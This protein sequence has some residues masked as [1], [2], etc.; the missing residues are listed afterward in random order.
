[1]HIAHASQ[2]DDSHHGSTRLHLNISD[3]V[4]IM[5]WAESRENGFSGCALWH[6]FPRRN[7]PIIRKFLAR[8]QKS[9]DTVDPI[10]SEQCYLAPIML[11]ALREQY[12][13]DPVIIYQRPGDAVFIPARCPYQ[14]R[15]PLPIYLPLT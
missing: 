4:N 8:V 1:M 9:A 15:I 14:V 7:T 5:T 6:I 12:C 3:T 2:H 11:D 13:I 10:Q